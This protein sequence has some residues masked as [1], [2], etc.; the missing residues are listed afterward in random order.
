MKMF[1]Q[2]KATSLIMKKHMQQDEVKPIHLLS[3]DSLGS[4]F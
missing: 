3:V 1:H 4:R 2:I